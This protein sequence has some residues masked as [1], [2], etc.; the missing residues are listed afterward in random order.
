LL[1]EARREY[2]FIKEADRTSLI[3]QPE[4]ARPNVLSCLMLLILLLLTE[5]IFVLKQFLLNPA[6]PVQFPQ[7]LEANSEAWKLV[8]KLVDPLLQREWSRILERPR[9]D[10][11]L[12]M[13]CGQW[14]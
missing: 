6:F 12:L 4:K 5:T 10:Q 7:Y 9:S 2:A 14:L 13:L 1:A 11:V 8:S 3:N